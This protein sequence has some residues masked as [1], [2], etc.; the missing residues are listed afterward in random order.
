MSIDTLARIKSPQHV[1]VRV[2]GAG[3]LQMDTHREREMG[4]VRDL[5]QAWFWTPGWLAGEAEA[6]LDIRNGRT[7]VFETAEDFL[8][9]LTD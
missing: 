4:L 8:A 7:R 2:R 3:A 1:V 9:S 6:T 5:S